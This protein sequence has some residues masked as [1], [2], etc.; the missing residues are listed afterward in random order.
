LAP[1]IGNCRCTK[2]GEIDEIEEPPQEMRRREV[3]KNIP[4]LTNNKQ[5]LS[6]G[7]FLLYYILATSMR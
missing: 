1:E 5:L 7:I 6:F 2:C 4:N 3:S